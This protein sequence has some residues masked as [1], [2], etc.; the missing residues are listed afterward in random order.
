[1]SP[2]TNK[3]SQWDND[4]MMKWKKKKKK[5]SKKPLQKKGSPTIDWSNVEALY[6]SRSLVK[7]I[8]HNQWKGFLFFVSE[9]KK[10]LNFDI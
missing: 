6:F 9:K 2:N 5:K 4:K 1:M 3:A 7:E 8:L 10:N